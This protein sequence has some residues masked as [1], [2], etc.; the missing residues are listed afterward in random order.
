MYGFAGPTMVQSVVHS[1]FA[2]YDF[3]R[4]SMRP[5][6]AVGRAEAGH[7]SVSVYPTQ[8]FN[9]TLVMPSGVGRESQHQYRHGDSLGQ[10]HAER[11]F[12]CAGSTARVSAEKKSCARER[13]A[14][15]RRSGGAGRQNRGVDRAA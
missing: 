12:R 4:Q 8:T 6:V 3:L 1:R 7:Y 9:K 2:N 5:A 15:R 13:G 14:G 10:G 11:S